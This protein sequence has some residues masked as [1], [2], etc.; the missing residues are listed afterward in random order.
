MI[1]PTILLAGT[2]TGAIIPPVVTVTFD[3]GANDMMKFEFLVPTTLN[4]GKAV[5]ESF[6]QT[7]ADELALLC[8]GS[9]QDSSPVQG[10]WF[11]DS[12]SRFS[13]QCLRFFVA[14]DRSMLPELMELVRRIGR[15]LKQEAMFVEVTG[16]DGPQILKIE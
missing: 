5:E 8:G 4:G 9:S 13:D 15:E 1:L 14:A 16:F 10:I 11:G 12:G 2:I 6:F 3:D 7:L